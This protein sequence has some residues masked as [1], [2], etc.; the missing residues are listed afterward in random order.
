MSYT[1]VTNKKKCSTDGCESL[2]LNPLCNA[3]RDRQKVKVSTMKICATP[4]C[5]G[6]VRT[7]TYCIKCTRQQKKKLTKCKTP[8]CTRN[9]HNEYCAECTNK[10]RR[11][12]N[13]QKRI[14]KKAGVVDE[15]SK[16]EDDKLIPS[17]PIDKDNVDS[18]SVVVPETDIS[19]SISSSTDIELDEFGTLISGVEMLLMDYGVKRDHRAKMLDSF[20]D[21]IESH[22]Y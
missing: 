18:S 21:I 4:Y 15:P 16:V 13:K 12:E 19:S 14:D 2:T 10:Q 20:I 1:K 3:C 17:D 5:E 9:C 8:N 7:K 6:K 22:G 11:E